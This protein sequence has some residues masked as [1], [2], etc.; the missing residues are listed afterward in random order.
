MTVAEMLAEFHAALGDAPGRGGAG[1]RTTLHCEEHD[2]LVHELTEDG[3]LGFRVA[4][5]DA[6]VDR[7]KLARELADV[8]YVAYGTA[9]AFDIDL[10][11]PKP[12]R[13]GKL[14]DDLWAMK[15]FPHA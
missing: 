3:P 4:R 7:A 12:G 10:S 6:D 15:E 2:E 8:V 9:H 14:P 13:R 1:L 5:P 11:G